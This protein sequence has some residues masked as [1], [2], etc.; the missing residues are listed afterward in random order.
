MSLQEFGNFLKLEEKASFIKE[1][2]KDFYQGN[3]ELFSSKD[4]HY[5]TR[6][7]LSFYH[8]KD[9]IYYAMFENK[10]KIIIESLE[11]ADEKI[12][13]F[14]PKLLKQIRNNT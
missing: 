6:A 7:E 1:F 12:T 14:M 11:F 8:D 5:R 2:F 9:E 4:K 13:A 3:F 10:K